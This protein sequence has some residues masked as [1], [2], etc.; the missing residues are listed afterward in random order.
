MYNFDKMFSDFIVSKGHV[1]EDEFNEAY[2]EWLHK[3]IDKF[4]CSPAE[5]L[6]KMTDA[7]M[8]AE[9]KEECENDCPSFTVMENLEKRAPIEL[10]TPLLYEENQTLVYCAAELLR[11]LDKIP[12][13]AFV[14]I[15]TETDDDELF[16]LI[17]AALK[18]VPDKVREKLLKISYGAD[19][20]IKTVIAE[21]L[22]EGGRDER[23]FKLLSELFAS[24]DNIPLYATYLARYGDER[25]AAMLY[26]ALDNAR[27]GDYI[28]I[29]NA[30]E[31]LGGVVDDEYRDFSEDP[32]YIKIKENRN[33]RK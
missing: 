23:V 11:N 9:L 21:I 29:R 30:I 26:R 28:E 1:H 6:D 22:C 16:E 25:A 12:L 5:I 24:G 8:V 18:D 27:Y 2:E 19:M 3:R 7:E 31:A 13:D 15:M 10:L 4:G 33:G 32:D 14:D 17:V 20:R